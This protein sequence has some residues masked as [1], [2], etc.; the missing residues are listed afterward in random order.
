VIFIG[1]SS[2]FAAAANAFDPVNQKISASVAIPAAAAP[3]AY[4]VCAIPSGTAAPSCP[5]GDPFETAGFIVGS[6][7]ALP[8]SSILPNVAPQCATSVPI[9]VT[10]A[11]THFSA[12]TVAN[13][14][15][16][17]TV[18]PV[19]PVN[20]SPTQ[21]AVNV[22]V[23]CLAPPGP[24]TVT[25]VTGGEF[26]VAQSGFTISSGSASISQVSPA[27]GTQGQ[28]L[29]VTLT[30]AGT[31]WL[32]SGT[33]VS[34]GGGINVGNV[35]VN[36]AAQTLAAS[37]SIGPSASPG[38]YSITATT[39]GEVAAIANGFTVTQAA[40]PR[41]LSV[42]PTTAVQ[43]AQGLAITVNAANTQFTSFAPAFDF[44]ANVSTS[45]RVV[46]DTQAIVT[47]NIDPVAFTGAR[48]V[49]MSSNGTNLTFVFTV[50]PD[51]ATILAVT[52]STLALGKS[53]HLTVQGSGANW[54][55]GTTQASLGAAFI[56]RVSIASSN[57]A[58]VDVTLPS[59]LPTGTT[60]LTM[61]TGGEV[62]SFPTNAINITGCNP[63]LSL[64][65]SSGMIGTSVAV[66]FAAD[67]VAFSSSTFATIDGQGVTLSPM[68]FP[69][70]MSTGNATFVISP[71]APAAP[72]APNQCPNRTVTLTVPGAPAQVLTAPFCVTST[73]AV[74]TGITPYHAPAG[75]GLTVAIAGSN[76]HF[77]PS[78]TVGLGPNVAVGTPNVASATQLAAPLVID[79]TA[80]TGWRQAYVNTGSEQLQIGFY[81]D[82]PPCATCTVP[83]TPSISSVV[84]GSLAQG[85]GPVTVTIAGSNTDFTSA[86][87]PILGQGVIVQSGSWHAAADGLSGTVVVSIDP[88]TPV[89]PRN[90]EAITNYGGTPSAI[91]DVSGPGFSVTPGIASILSVGST[92]A[93][94]STRL[95]VSQGQSA[96]SFSI[97]GGSS[98]FL[99]GATTVD[100][101]AGIT[102]TDFAVVDTTHI[103][104]HVT[105]G[106]SAPAGLR[107]ITVTTEG[108]VAQS[109]SDAVLVNLTQPSGLTITPAAAQQGTEVGVQVQ[110]IGT[111]WQNGITTASFGNNNG[112]VVKSFTVNN[113]TQQ[114]VID[115]V[116]SGTTYITSP[117]VCC[118]LPYS[119]TVT[120]VTQGGANIEQE[121]LA[122]VFSVGPGAAIVTSVSPNSGKQGTT[123]NVAIAGQN[124][125][126]LNG[127]TTALMTT[128][129][130]PPAWYSLADVNVANVVVPQGDPLHATLSVAISPTAPTGLRT[131]CVF[132]GGE[133][134]AYTNAFTVLPGTPTLNGV[135]PVGGQQGQTLTLN[136]IGQFTHWGAAT[137]AT[138][139]PGVTLVGN[140]QIADSQTAS[141]QVSIDPLA[142]VGPRTVTLTTGTEIVSGAFFSVT[143]SA[144]VITGISPTT[145]NQGA[146]NVLIQINGNAT[147]WAQGATQFYLTGD[148]ISFNGFQ[149]TNATTA[150]ADITISPTATPSARTVYMATGGEILSKANSFVVTGGIP[151]LTCVNPN[152]LTQGR[153]GANVQ[154]CG[155]Y[156]AWTAANTHV[157]IDSDLTVTGATTV[158]NN[159]SITAVVNVGTAA[160][161]GLHTLT[162]QTGSQVLTA[163][164]NVIGSGGGGGSSPPPAPYISYQNPGAALVGQTLNVNFSGAYTN[165][166]PGTSAIGFGAGIAVNSFQVTGLTSAVANITIDAHATV[167]SRTVTI[168]TGATE[169]ESASFNITVGT[170][171]LSLIDPASIFQGQTRDF[172][173]VGQF[174][175]FN[176]A[177]SFTACAGI[178]VSNVRIMGPTAARI[179]LTASPVAAT[180]TCAL[181]ESGAE[182]A[183]GQFSIVPG[184]AVIT[185]VGPNTALQGAIVTGVSIAGF[186]THW[187][188]GSTSFSFG[189]GIAVSS[190]SITS[191]TSATVTL[192]LDPLA[193]VG[194]YTATAQ[195]GGETAILN[196]A[197]VVQPGTPILLSSTPS[198]APQQGS[199]SLGILGQYTSFATGATTVGLGAGVLG[200]A[201][202]VTAANALTVT[203]SVDP[204]AFPGSRNITVSTVSGGKT[205]VLTLY[206]AFAI[207][208]GPAAVSL[209]AP[210]Q[211]SQGQ[212]LNVVVTGTN[213]HFTRAAPAASFGPGVTVNS[214]AVTDDLHATVN[215]SVSPQ[216]VPGQFNV[217]MTTL[218]EVASAQG[219]FTVIASTPVISF[220]NPNSLAQGQ[221]A[222]VA[223][224]GTFTGFTNSSVV[225]FGAGIAVNSV[226]ASNGQNLTANITVS[227]TAFVG[228]RAV[229]VDSVSLP[230]GFTVTS[231]A[232]TGGTFAYTANSAEP[233]LSGYFINP[234]TGILTPLTDSPYHG[235]N[236]SVTAVVSPSG[237]FVYGVGGTIS[238]YGVNATTG[239][240]TQIAGSPVSLAAGAAN[241]VFA[242]SGR[243][244]YICE[245]GAIV[246]YAVNTS[247]GL[248]A[249]A[250]VASVV[251]DNLVVSPSGQF[252]WVLSGTAVTSYSVNAATGA[253]TQLAVSGGVAGTTP[254]SL[255]LSPSGSFLYATNGGSNSVSAFAVNP[256]TAALTAVLGSPFAAGAAPQSI[257]F[258]PAGALAY[259]A[260]SAPGNISAFTVNQSTGALTPVAGSPFTAGTTADFVTTDPSGSYLYSTNFGDST[261]SAYSINQANGALTG[262]AGS[263]YASG[264]KP[265]AIAIARV[266]VALTSVTPNSGVL[267]AASVPVTIT[268]H[269]THFDA[270]TTLSFGPGI[271]VNSLAEVTPAYLIANLNITSGAPTGPVTVTV[272]TGGEILA[273]PNAFTVIPGAPML[274]GS[275]P[276]AF[277][278]TIVGQTSAGIAVTI[279]NAGNGPAT[280]SGFTL[281]GTNPGDFAI[282]NNNCGTTLAINANCAVTVT[283]S[284]AATGSRS[285]MLSVASNAAGS[286]LTV[287]LS[288]TGVAPTYLVSVETSQAFPA[289]IV[290]QSS[291]SIAV[292]IANSGNS[293]VAFG[294]T[295]F[296]IGGANPS[297][298]SYAGSTCGTTLAASAVCSVSL[299]FNPT[300]A[301]AR[302]A[303]L[304][305]ADSAAG[306]PQQVAL[307]GTGQTNVLSNYVNLS[308]LVNGDLTTY[309]NGSNYPPGGGPL[310]VAGVPFVLATIAPN[311]HTAVVQGSTSPGVAQTYSIPVNVHGV[312]TVGTLMNSIAGACGTAVGE[313][314]FIGAASA[315][316]V[317]VLTE[318]VNIR[319]YS[320]G[321]NC[322]TAAQVAGTAVFNGVRLDMQQISLPA[323]FA[324]DTLLSVTFKSYGAGTGGAPFLAAVTASRTVTAYPP[325]TIATAQLPSDITGVAYSQTVAASG[326][327]SPLAYSIS[328]GSL[329]AGLSLDP[330]FGTIAGTP[331][332]VGVAGFTLKVTDSVGQTQSA[333]LQIAVY[334][335]PAFVTS[336]LPAGRRTFPYV[337]QTIQFSGGVPPVAMSVTS[338]MLPAGLS[339]NPA[340]NTISG[341]PGAAGTFNFQL[342]IADANGDMAT[343]NFSLLVNDLLSITTA[344]LP[345]GTVGVNY[346]QTV[347]TANGQPPVTFAVI[348]GTLPAGLNL[349]PA[350][351]L[352]SGSPS[353]AGTASFMVQ[354]TDGLN[355][356]AADALSIVVAPPPLITNVSPA[357]GNVGQTLNVTITGQNTHFTTGSTTASFGAGTTATLM[358][359]SLTSA[360]ASVTIDANAAQGAR[361][362]VLTTGTEVAT[363]SGGF[364]V[365]AAPPVLLSVQPAS[366]AV[367]TT[368]TI[369]VTGQNL[370]GAAFQLQN[371]ISLGS[372]SSTVTVGSQVYT[373]PLST[374]TPPGPLTVVSNNGT[375]AVLTVPTGASTGQF[376]LVATTSIGSSAPTNATQFAVR[377]FATQNSVFPP[378]S[379]LNTALGNIP[380]LPPGSNHISTVAS[381]LNQATSGPL[382]YVLPPGS[383]HIST[384]ASVLN[385]ATSGPLGYVLPPGSSHISTVASVLNQA[386]SGPLGY[387]LPPGSN[388]I[389][390]AAS[391]M[392]TSTAGIGVYTPPAG[393]NKVSALTVSVCDQPS[394]CPAGTQ[395][396]ISLTARPDSVVPVT[397]GSTTP[398]RL[399]PVETMGSVIEGR[400]ILLTAQ[401]TDG[402]AFV[403]YLVDGVAVARTAGA[404]HKMQF[405]VPSGVTY[406]SFQALVH[407]A[408]G[409]V[410]ASQSVA[411]AVSPDTGESVAMPA[412]REGQTATLAAHGWRADFY[413]WNAPLSA[414]PDLSGQVP[415][416]TAW[417]TALNQPNPGAVFGDDPLGAGL[418]QDFVARYSAEIWI[419]TDGTYAFWLSA[420][421]GASLQIDGR[422]IVGGDFTTGLPTTSAANMTLR[423][424]WHKIVANYF[425]AVGAESAL[426]EW[427]QPGGRR[428]V[429]GPANVR[430]GLTGVSPSSVPARFDSVW[431]QVQ[432]GSSAQDIPVR[433]RQ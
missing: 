40:A 189:S 114:G 376:G 271:A 107:G 162:V 252:A 135:S 218:G 206:N 194:E 314:D 220:V 227:P 319:D 124:T 430:T 375:T 415:V 231:G 22:T 192:T 248:P 378:A 259:V 188:T 316:Y 68:S 300:A 421:S 389:G 320:G 234:G 287:A 212:T 80:V 422:K 169:N 334:A 348:S 200:V 61:A 154:I 374:P 269:G 47:V 394:G 127:T 266:G 199:F 226:S 327:A 238:V 286:P 260:N 38:P 423:A 323:G 111:S 381:V 172:D 307:S 79:P 99:T 371:E 84:P 184:T 144:A 352:I 365:V 223:I 102:V 175:T 28:N 318:G 432:Q 66:G 88:R 138:F 288:G 81:I 284:P 112:L 328:A 331:T 67:C 113:A 268:G 338:G 27:T 256:S 208:A 20:G 263:P 183:T 52:P 16:G 32:Q 390:T 83:V 280:F 164:V 215:I 6:T 354:A 129:T 295:P 397:A 30:G 317:Y 85:Q 347:Q 385:Q 283:F 205:Q 86:T 209:T 305:I 36:Q 341:T 118:A 406:L 148:G 353:Q 62:A 179:A 33:V 306:N 369:T 76:T 282:S 301:G 37:V 7:T 367:N 332:A 315:P 233:D 195:T 43:G 304:N 90:V 180:G 193:T 187:A 110:G 401:S 363:A 339:F 275:A 255:V 45:V 78:S 142:N 276:P 41:I 402:A 273:L 182:A 58:Y 50:Q 405:T 13:F 429:L 82:P 222:D 207:T 77:G 370:L 119:L 427:Q 241:L 249:P 152:T 409:K 221:T 18:G 29:T 428:E 395:Q 150:I 177:T 35:T 303:T 211:A 146:Q 141:A 411:V 186:G 42:T 396:Q 73:P 96:A 237:Q 121:S 116:I 49:T 166:L 400:T 163:H 416:R 198:S 171:I 373:I 75:A 355:L 224:A 253:L 213:T 336:T 139:G 157:V 104:G 297:D 203:G 51:S 95:A 230:S 55:Q 349:N 44:L 321:G 105:V 126:F 181:T 281:T 31:H 123:L 407:Y 145:A 325:L 344:S 404:P 366:A 246:V 413:R 191:A 15:D 125:N 382:G 357:Q 128:S 219:L 262:L 204:V 216:A 24:R 64:S 399:E 267:G 311:S 299:V 94:Q 289:T 383:N 91:Q 340:N 265:H 368:A 202:T 165:W 290:G 89:G 431:V 418:T 176:A 360:V 243:F 53:Y 333:S 160:A 398:P 56:N 302:A 312:T 1:Q 245:A 343:Q 97:L 244:A 158:N 388:H 178:T 133:V 87:I 426:L 358:V 330:W 151:A 46:T 232:A 120:T 168:S 410:M 324:S 350:T 377:S 34:F 372:T 190:P 294:A 362:V 17:V 217:T 103:T 60:G 254:T 384:V 23:D 326:G 433:I 345:G 4:T 337:P 101:G 39:N 392:N 156:T 167:G 11:N 170:P 149:V 239:T 140:L 424:G 229:S 159:T 214:V 293:S 408:S 391:V 387:V 185:S 117:Y 403:D 351:G 161:L 264:A 261:V 10:G 137:T 25:F 257:S 419:P 313:L 132:T 134:A 342:G 12:A 63:T 364:T 54:V 8:L 329:P 322:N 71:T 48:T 414:L 21:A 196:N 143:P 277:P 201:V 361:D 57:L 240:L 356:T 106:S 93:T 420:R 173:V 379:V 270:T 69:A 108:E 386:T 228:A 19:T 296:T 3:G 335:P 210:S 59:A 153:Q 174:T 258:T 65:P 122:N 147:H 279:S 9:T 285:A 197:F 100:F 5:A 92:P 136:I 251:G 242:P 74:L 393:Q 235:S 115:L 298:F 291:A 346:S 70:G 14:G 359:N 272:S 247:T 131:L 2:W 130:C 308:S 155:A 292:S 310:T 98:N 274:S 236:S 309:A 380:V 250:G 26:A 417:A 109:S 72:A 225:S 412:L 278:G 425:L